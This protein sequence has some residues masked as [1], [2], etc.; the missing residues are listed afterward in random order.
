[1]LIKIDL[2]LLDR[3]AP[4]VWYVDRYFAKAGRHRKPA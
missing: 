4:L 2:W 3:M 1:M